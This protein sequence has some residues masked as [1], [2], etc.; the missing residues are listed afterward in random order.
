[1]KVIRTI[2][3][4]TCISVFFTDVFLMNNQSLFKSWQKNTI[5]YPTVHGSEIP[6]NHLKCIKTQ[7]RLS[8]STGFL[9]GFL[10]H[11]QPII[12]AN[13]NSKGLMRFHESQELGKQIGWDLPQ[14]YASFISKHVGMI[15]VSL[16]VYVMMICIYIQYIYNTHWLLVNYWQYIR[17]ICDIRIPPRYLWVPHWTKMDGETVWIPSDQGFEEI[18]WK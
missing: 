5:N 15:Y 3:L 12:C 14:G 9:V 2:K 10:K 17:N 4:S 16:I 7:G 13:P 1:M 8:I 11:Q 18:I 6:N